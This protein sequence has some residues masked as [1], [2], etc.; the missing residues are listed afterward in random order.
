[1]SI[2]NFQEFHDSISKDLSCR[3]KR[4]VYAHL[5]PFKLFTREEREIAQVGKVIEECGEL[6][7]AIVTK[8]KRLGTEA[9]YNEVRGTIESELADVVIAVYG[10]AAVSDTTVVS[11]NENPLPDLYGEDLIVSRIMV[12]VGECAFSRLVCELFYY[13]DRE[14]I[15]LY[16]NV[17]ERLYFN[18]RE[19][20]SAKRNKRKVQ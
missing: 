2:T 18:S 10:Y 13:C 6:I 3:I 5:K 9:T 17:K 19:I 11:R 1:M 12:A 14:G 16:N 7:Y 8:A 15:N 4:N 20:E